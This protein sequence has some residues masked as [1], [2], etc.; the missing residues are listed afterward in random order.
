MFSKTSVDALTENRFELLF[1]SLI[2][3]TTG[4]K[5]ADKN[6][7]TVY[8]NPTISNQINI[9]SNAENPIQKVEIYSMDG[10]L[11]QT[12]KTENHQNAE[13]QMINFD[14]KGNFLMK[15]IGSKSVGTEIVIFK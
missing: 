6:K 13:I 2:E 12:F 7:F 10:K 4:L 14:G 8:P 11:V 1:N 15:M 3:V 9:V 5:T